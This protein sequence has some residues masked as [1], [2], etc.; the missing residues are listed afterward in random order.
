M[1]SLAL[2]LT[3]IAIALAVNALIVLTAG[4]LAAA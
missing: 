2:G 1:R 3:Q 4:S